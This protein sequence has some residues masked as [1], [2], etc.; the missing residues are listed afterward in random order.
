MSKNPQL[1]AIDKEIKAYRNNLLKLIKLVDITHI[2]F[3]QVIN[4]INHLKHKRQ[5]VLFELASNKK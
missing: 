5:L 3:Y 4:D 1:E 2:D